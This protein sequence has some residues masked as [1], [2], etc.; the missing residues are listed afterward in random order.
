MRE[1]IEYPVFANQN[2]MLWELIQNSLPESG[3]IYEKYGISFYS[4]LEQ[5]EKEYDY[6][7]NSYT[8][9]LYYL[10]GKAFKDADIKNT[11][12]LMDGCAAGAIIPN[13]LGFAGAGVE[14]RI[15]KIIGENP[16]YYPEM[17]YG[18]NGSKKD[19][20]PSSISLNKNAYQRL[21]KSIVELAKESVNIFEEDLTDFQ[22]QRKHGLYLD[23]LF[24]HMDL[25]E[26]YSDS[27]FDDI[28]EVPMDDEL[29]LELFR[30]G[31]IETE[32]GT[33]TVPIQEAALVNMIQR[34]N[35]QTIE[36]MSYAMGLYFYTNSILPEVRTDWEREL[37]N[38]LGVDSRTGQRVRVF[39]EDYLKEFIDIGDE[40]LF[41]EKRKWC[42]K[43]QLFPRVHIDGRVQLYYRLAYYLVHHNEWE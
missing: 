21:I 1:K 43:H 31:T 14:D 2:E 7:T 29:T 39:R 13:I 38:N 42:I 23:E 32:D 22:V 36:D 17:F 24:D 12:V 11:E 37:D 19:A 10:L 20:N 16:I 18:V 30:K 8:A 15:G 34:F 40:D 26:K 41:E 28:E 6:I 9:G 5:V 25:S 27:P 4:F 33:I 35:P 3:T